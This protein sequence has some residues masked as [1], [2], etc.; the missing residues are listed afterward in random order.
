MSGRGGHMTHLANQVFITKKQFIFNIHLQVLYLLGLWTKNLVTIFKN[1][2]T[3][4]IFVKVLYMRKP[5]MS[6]LGE[7]KN[8]K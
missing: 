5:I 3:A 2:K 6:D 8:I 4:S 7:S 1:E